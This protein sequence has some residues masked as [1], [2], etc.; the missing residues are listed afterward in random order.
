M[1]SKYPKIPAEPIQRSQAKSGTGT[2]HCYFSDHFS[3]DITW[4]QSILNILSFKIGLCQD[5]S[6]VI[7][8]VVQRIC[9]HQ[10]K[11][12]KNLLRF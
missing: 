9:L 3:G 2:S 1:S 8:T 12:K 4:K 10:E 6:K 7:K 11:K 5:L